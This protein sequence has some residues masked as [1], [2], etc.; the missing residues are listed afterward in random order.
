MSGMGGGS[1]VGGMMGAT[2]TNI[3]GVVQAVARKNLAKKQEK[4]ATRLQQAAKYVPKE[5]LRP[6]Y[7]QV[8]DAQQ[9]GANFGLN[10]ISRY[11]QNIDKSVANMNRDAAALGSSGGA[12]LAALSGAY[13]KSL[14][15][16]NELSLR[17]S[18]MRPG[19]LNQLYATTTMIGDKQRDLE[20]ER[21]R[22]KELILAEAAALRVASS[23]NALA[24]HDTAAEAKKQASAMF[25]GSQAPQQ[26]QQGA[27]PQMQQQSMPVQSN[28]KQAPAQGTQWQTYGQGNMIQDTTPMQGG[29]TI[30]TSG[31]GGMN[32]GNW[33]G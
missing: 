5:Q 19:K 24:A 6:E 3:A 11:E 29:Q 20:L 4:E 26:M 28:Y 25:L 30:Q 15:A 23:A 27:Q 16:R 14:D 21:Q 17:D 10:N 13:T 22:K 2:S 1:W 18:E 7:Q 12:S 9:I 8:R 31:G 32:W 33:G